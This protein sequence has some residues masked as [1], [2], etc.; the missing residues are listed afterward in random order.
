M[1]TQDDFLTANKNGVVGINAIGEAVADFASR[2]SGEY[3]SLTVTART[4]IASGAGRLIAATIVIAGS[5]SGKVYDSIMP[6]TT[7]TS[8][9]G[10]NATV[11]YRQTYAFDAGDTV[12]V[13][14]VAPAGYNT[15]GTVI[16]SSTSTT[17]TYANVTT[18]G[19]TAAGRVFN[20]K[21]ANVITA[22]PTTIGTYF[23][24]A[25]FTTGLVIDPGTGQ[26]INVI[27]SLD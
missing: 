8:G 20:P 22:T 6:Q 16:V 13:S 17:V 25:P 9:T 15:T 12:I 3:R 11:T 18:G 27:Y 2:I 14:G 26:S 21:A 1:A 5:A 10:V 24:N 7:G 23:I 4:E 19:M